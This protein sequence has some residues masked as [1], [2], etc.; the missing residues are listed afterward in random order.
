MFFLCQS[1]DKWGLTNIRML[2]G[3]DQTSK[4]R[5]GKDD[6]GGPLPDLPQQAL[7]VSGGASRLLRKQ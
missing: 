2:H 3:K 5:P 6:Q 4:K 7:L 1:H